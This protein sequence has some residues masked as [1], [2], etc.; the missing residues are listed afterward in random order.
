MSDRGERTAV[1]TGASSGIGLAAAR[2]LA[3][4]GWHVIAL[5]RSPE[6]SREAL[7]AIKAKAPQA[8]VEMF[9]ADL[10]IL[11]EA[12]SVAERIAA[13]APRIDLL[14][15]NAGGVPAARRETSEGFEHTFAANHLGPFVLTRALLPQLKAAG[16]GAQVINISSSAHSF[17]PDMKWDDLQLEHGKF[18]VSSA[19]AQSKLANI[20]F[21]RALSK[22]LADDGISVN[23]V[24]PGLVQSNFD[25]HG[26]W[27][28]KL[29]YKMSKLT[30]LSLS[31]EQGADTI[32][33]LTEQQQP[34]SGHYFVKRKIAATTPAAQSSEG[35]ERLWELSS[36][37]ADQALEKKYSTD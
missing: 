12:R 28:I 13:L 9:Q 16:A 18:D 5:G 37:L 14:V 11:T 3:C 21:T 32:L 33:W 1:V 20:L 29:I 10:S 6:R 22:R 15:N 30:R 31:P 8:Q 7:A 4:R 2:E 27:M 34:G 17:V 26:N 35:A 36:Q 25:T 19:Y 24:H 23:A